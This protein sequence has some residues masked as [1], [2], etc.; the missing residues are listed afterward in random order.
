MM[1]YMCLFS[2]ILAQIVIGAQV[3]DG[4]VIFLFGKTC[5]LEMPSFAWTCTSKIALQPFGAGNAIVSSGF[6][7]CMSA[8]VWLSSL[9]L[10]SNM[11][12][13]FISAGL[14]LFAAST[15]FWHFASRTYD[16]LVPGR[17][18]A[19]GNNMSGV[20]G[21]VIFNYSFITAVPCVL[22]SA[23]SAVR[24]KRVVAA[25]VGT[26]CFLYITMGI[27][28]SMAFDMPDAD[29]MA[30]LLK[31]DA[32]VVTKLAVFGFTHAIVP[33]IPVYCLLLQ[34]GFTQNLKWSPRASYSCSSLV[35]WMIALFFY[36]GDGFFDAL[37]RWASLL[38]N[39]FV[40]LVFPLALYLQFSLCPHGTPSIP[41][42]KSREFAVLSSPG[43]SL[44]RCSII[45]VLLV[46][47]FVIMLN[48]GI[49][50]T[51]ALV[52]H[53]DFTSHGVGD[54]A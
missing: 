23:D 5:A 43:L 20:L 33:C 50:L 1:F 40:N 41:R 7:I 47:T 52:L 13:Q 21:V 42:S 12:P 35:P 22:N 14:L 49:A 10:S 39:G 2:L 15:F 26:M 46:V 29:V 16:P 28:G 24:M 44:G 6:L 9:D 32:P 18:P 37:V 17:L 36:N 11:L 34:S 54:P 3:M 38:V 51:Y 31:P 8:C 25:G 19:I 27:L 48:I 30:S 45:A 4:F 53:E